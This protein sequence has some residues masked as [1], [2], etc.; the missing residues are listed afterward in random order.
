MAWDMR[1]YFEEI[2]GEEEERKGVITG[3]EMRH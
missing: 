1:K 3:G 2:E